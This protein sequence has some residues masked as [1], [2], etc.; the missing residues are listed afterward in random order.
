MMMVAR[1]AQGILTGSRGGAETA[2]KPRR[3]HAQGGIARRG[4]QSGALRV[5]APPR[6]PGG[7]SHSA[8]TCLFKKSRPAHVRD[9]VQIRRYL[10]RFRAGTLSPALRASERPIAI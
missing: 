5:P 8:L 4:Q 10:E 2:E 7:D 9:E 6:E 3:P 1:R